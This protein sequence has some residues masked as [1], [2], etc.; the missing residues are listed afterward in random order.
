[1]SFVVPVLLDINVYTWK[2]TAFIKVGKICSKALI[3]WLFLFLTRI[4][5]LWGTCGEPVQIC[6]LWEHH[7]RVTPPHLSKSMFFFFHQPWSSSSTEAAKPSRM[8]TPNGWKKCFLL[9][10][11]AAVVWRVC[12]RT[13]FKTSV[14][15]LMTVLYGTAEMLSGKRQKLER[16]HSDNKPQ[17]SEYLGAFCVTVRWGLFKKTEQK[18]WNKIK[19]HLYICPRLFFSNRSRCV[20]VKW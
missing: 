20:C 9:P 15:S 17:G 1:M 10:H 18:K 4:V 11:R 8:G 16:D 3:L 19:Q 13:A 5:D 12:W 2:L 7:T 14:A 6:L